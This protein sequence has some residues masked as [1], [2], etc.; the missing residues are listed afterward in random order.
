MFEE[1]TDYGD[2]DLNNALYFWHLEQ[3]SSHTK[4]PEEILQSQ[5][6]AETT[7]AASIHRNNILVT[8][9]KVI[10]LLGSN[11]FERWLSMH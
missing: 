4:I 7:C 1:T 6:G 5:E 9:E 11:S 3:G 10:R 8:F 2:L